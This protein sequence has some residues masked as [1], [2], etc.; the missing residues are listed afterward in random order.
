ME[1]RPIYVLK[2]TQLDSNY[3]YSKRV[4][5]IDKET[6]NFYQIEN[7]DQKGRLYRTVEYDWSFVSEMGQNVAIG[8]TFL[9]IDHL[10]KHSSISLVY[11]LPAFCQRAHFGLKG[12]ARSAK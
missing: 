5:Y 10:E 8:S 6:F 1:R 3:V 9:Y 11:D 2:L 4:F 12:I 7:Y